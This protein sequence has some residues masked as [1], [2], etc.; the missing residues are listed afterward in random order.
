MTKKTRTPGFFGKV[1]LHDTIAIVGYRSGRARGHKHCSIQKRS[2]IRVTEKFFV[3]DDETKLDF[4]GRIL[5]HEPPDVYH[6]AYW[7]TT[8]DA[9]VVDL[10]HRALLSK[11]FDKLLASKE[12]LLFGKTP[13]PE[14][15]VATLQSAL[16]MLAEP[17]LSKERMN[18]LLA[19]GRAL[20]AETE[21][22]LAPP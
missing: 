2:V 6:T 3:L 8:H 17:Q 9:M 1:K 5:R 15:L 7:D 12:G 18:E 19:E 13:V 22:R 4:S 21:K 20:R 10:A 16:A 11:T 14:N